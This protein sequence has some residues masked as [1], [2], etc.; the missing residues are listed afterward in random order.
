MRNRVDLFPVP[1][2]KTNDIEELVERERRRRTRS[3]I[4][5]FSV[6]GDGDDLAVGICLTF[7]VVSRN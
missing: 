7:A 1:L 3:E 6:C 4:A 5:L 2:Y